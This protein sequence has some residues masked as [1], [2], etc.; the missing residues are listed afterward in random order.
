MKRIL[1]LFSALLLFCISFSVFVFLPAKNLMAVKNSFNSI[2]NS[3]IAM[4]QNW[5]DK[6]N[7]MQNKGC[8]S[9]N[10]ATHKNISAMQKNNVTTKNDINKM[11]KSVV[12]KINKQQASTQE[13]TEVAHLFTHALISQ[14][15]GFDKKN[16]MNKY[17]E[18][19]CLSANEFEDILMRLYQNDYV[20][21]DIDSVYYHQKGKIFKKMP[22][23]PLGKKPLILSFDDINFYVKKMN[24]GMNDKIIVS[25]GKLATYT[26]NAKNQINYNNEVVTVLENFIAKHPTFSVNNARGIIC[27]TGFD[28]ILGYRTNAK[29]PIRA[30]EIESVK[31]VIALLKQKNWKFAC[32]SFGHYHMQQQTETAFCNDIASWINEVEPLVGKTNLYCYPYGE[33]QIS[34]PNN[35]NGKHQFLQQ[36]GFDVFFSV[37]DAKYFVAKCNNTFLFQDR[38]PLDGNTLLKRKRI[39]QPYFDT[40]NLLDKRRNYN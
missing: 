35:L 29:S 5:I 40:A 7:K 37:G 13:T 2:K 33:W 23:V 20:L 27:L 34:N 39:L 38:I 30:T 18:Q 11:H 26:K 10:Y 36:N 9:K 15:I 6:D 4:Q 3:D 17:Y 22:N 19:D 31:P 8:I 24:L 16:D 12:Q 14:D 1:I 21:V 32:H 25:N 28:G